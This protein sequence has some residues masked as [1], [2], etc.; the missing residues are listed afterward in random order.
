MNFHGGLERLGFQRKEGGVEGRLLISAGPPCIAPLN[1]QGGSFN[2]HDHHVFPAAK[3]LYDYDLN[4]GGWNE[5]AELYPGRV[6]GG[7][8]ERVRDRARH[9]Q[10]FTTL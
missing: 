7:Q 10:S 2:Q 6:E 8:M 9:H 3:A 5:R 4:A 1:L